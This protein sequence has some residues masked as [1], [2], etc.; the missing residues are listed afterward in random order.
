MAHAELAEM[1]TKGRETIIITPKPPKK[2][3]NKHVKKPGDKT[4]VVQTEGHATIEGGMSG[5]TMDLGPQVGY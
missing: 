4:P 1:V 3:R 2:G 5:A